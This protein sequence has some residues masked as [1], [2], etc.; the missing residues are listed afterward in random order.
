VLYTLNQTGAENMAEAAAYYPKAMMFVAGDDS[1][2]KPAVM[3]LVS[4]LGFHAVDAGP[5]RAAAARTPR[6]AVDRT[7]HEARPCAGFRLRHGS[8]SAIFQT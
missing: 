1:A 5:L 8:P 7:G 3:E 4:D 6:H 2:H